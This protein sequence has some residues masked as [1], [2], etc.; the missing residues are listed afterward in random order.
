[1]CQLELVPYFFASGLFPL[2]V[3]FHSVDWHLQSTPNLINLHAVVGLG[4]SKYH[5]KK[6][7]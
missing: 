1:M 6:C 2:Q 4:A 7:V 5:A 3:Y